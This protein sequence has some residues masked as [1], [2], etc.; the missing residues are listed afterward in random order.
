MFARVGTFA[1]IPLQIDIGDGDSFTPTVQA[2]S[3]PCPLHR[4]GRWATVFTTRPT[5]CG[6]H[7]PRSRSS[8]TTWADDYENAAALYLPNCLAVSARLMLVFRFVVSGTSFTIERVMISAPPARLM[9][10]PSARWTCVFAFV[11]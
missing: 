9:E 7:Q 6:S 11:V 8:A 1:E 4:K 2:L 3:G 5:G 10:S